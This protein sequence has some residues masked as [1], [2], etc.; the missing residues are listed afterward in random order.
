MRSPWDSCQTG[1]HAYPL[2]SP[3]FIGHWAQSPL[4][5]AGPNLSNP[6]PRATAGYSALG[7]IIVSISIL[8]PSQKD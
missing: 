2:R 6:T 3:N 7:A 4:R 5:L 1:V 8:N